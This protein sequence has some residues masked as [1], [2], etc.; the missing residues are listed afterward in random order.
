MAVS[1]QTSDCSERCENCG[2]HVTLGFRRVFGDGD[3]RAR[4][5]E[6]CDTWN[7]IESGSAAGRD[8]EIPDPQAN[9]E[10]QPVGWSA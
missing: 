2:A 8:V 3:N 4:R 6:N 7:R 9:T 10:R 1:H 5:C